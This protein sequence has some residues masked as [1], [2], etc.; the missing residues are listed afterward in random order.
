MLCNKIY[1]SSTSQENAKL[2][3]QMVI[4]IYT[5]TSSVQSS[6]GF[7][8]LPIL[9]SIRCFNMFTMF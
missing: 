4:P 5:S 6:Y 7:T 1:V 2:C 8:S 3:P 9:V